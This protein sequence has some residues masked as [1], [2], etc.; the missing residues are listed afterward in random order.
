MRKEAIIWDYS[1]SLAHSS[2]NIWRKKTNES[3]SRASVISRVRAHETACKET[4][5]RNK[6][7]SLLPAAWT[8]LF[9]T[10][11]QNWGQNRDS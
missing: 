10:Y 1:T 3:K 4:V 2:E 7:I 5:N 6:L 8:N 9:Q 11:G